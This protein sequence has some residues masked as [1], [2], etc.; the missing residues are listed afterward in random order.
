MV[1]WIV[2]SLVKVCEWMSERIATS[3]VNVVEKMLAYLV[4][5]KLRWAR[6]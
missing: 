1:D 3:F 5:W 2:T 6:G 4:K